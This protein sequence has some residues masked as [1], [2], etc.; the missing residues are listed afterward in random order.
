[1]SYSFQSEK[2]LF[3]DEVGDRTK[4]RGEEQRS[5]ENVQEAFDDTFGAALAAA[6]QLVG[7]LGKGERTLYNV[8]INGHANPDHE[9][10]FKG[11]ANEAIN[12]SINVAGTAPE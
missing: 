11:W 5:P 8:S 9:N 1:M 6:A 12:I 4:Y 2:P 3:A 10:P 7:T